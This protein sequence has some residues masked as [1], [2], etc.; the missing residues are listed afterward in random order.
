MP[1]VAVVC[2]VAVVVPI[3]GFVLRVTPSLCLQP[4]IVF[5][6]WVSLSLACVVSLVDEFGVALAVLL[7]SHMGIVK[8]VCCPCSQ[9]LRVTEHSGQADQEDVTRCR[10]TTSSMPRHVAEVAATTRVGPYTCLDTGVC[11]AG[12]GPGPRGPCRQRSAAGC[13]GKGG[14]SACLPACSSA[15]QHHT[16][17]FV[18]RSLTRPMLFD[19]C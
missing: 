6:F 18:L 4:Y 5:W 15:R 1:P 12:S 3:C 8:V 10:A 19:K 7:I 13:A 2:L 11:G 16:F 9:V 17:V 14:G